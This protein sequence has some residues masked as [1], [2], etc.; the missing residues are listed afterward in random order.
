MKKL[1]LNATKHIITTLLG[2]IVILMG[3]TF[4]TLSWTEVVDNDF[5]MWMLAGFL[6]LGV[7][8]IFSPDNLVPIMIKGLSNFVTKKTK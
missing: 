6:A 4:F 7:L 8:L 1:L 2:I 5:S 3:L